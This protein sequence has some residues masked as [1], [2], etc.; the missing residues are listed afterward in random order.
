MSGAILGS[1]LPDSPFNRT[2]FNITLGDILG[3]DSE[4]QDRK[5][6]L[7]LADGTTLQIHSIDDLE[8]QY[9]TVKAYRGQDSDSEPG[10]HLIPY[11]I[12]Y[13][14]ELEP[15]EADGSRRLGFNW[16]PAKPAKAAARS[17]KKKR[18]S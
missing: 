16:K 15:K 18:R 9:L 6:T 5:L 7:F 12:I 10:V 17:S 11:V 3:E 1:G 14:I 4:K 8:E 13:R 2:F